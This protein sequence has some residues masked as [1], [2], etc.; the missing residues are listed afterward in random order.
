MAC[1]LLKFHFSAAFSKLWHL[2]SHCSSVSVSASL[3]LPPKLCV[4]PVSDQLS[5]CGSLRPHGRRES[6]LVSTA[7]ACTPRNT[8]EFMYVCKWSVKSVPT[9]PIHFCIVERQQVRKH[10]FLHVGYLE[11]VDTVWPA[12]KVLEFLFELL[13]FAYTEAAVMCW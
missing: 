11:L 3:H 1:Q 9:R 7:Y 13:Q 12:S 6:G 2:A 8:W 10:I 5:Y 4:S